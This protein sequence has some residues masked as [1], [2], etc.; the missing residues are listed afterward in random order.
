MRTLEFWFD[1]SCPYAYVASTQ[2]E[3]LAAGCGATLAWRPMLLGGVFRAVGT[4][5][6]L[7]PTLPPA[8]AR[9]LLIDQHR[10]AARAGVPL[11]PPPEHPRRTVAALRA[12][13]ARG[14]DPSV[15]HAF[16]RAYWTERRAIEDPAVVR[17]IAGDVDLEAQREPL[18]QATEAAIA[19]GIF[20][21]PAYVVDGR[22]WWGQDRVPMVR[23]AL[24]AG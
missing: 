18:R 9:Y 8:K 13:L 6:H 12:T 5:Q 16:F 22:M 10:L 1:Y 23:R 15:I 20:G 19:L 17:D 24:E 11:D 7:A 3:R 2:V 14:M 4:A 21:A